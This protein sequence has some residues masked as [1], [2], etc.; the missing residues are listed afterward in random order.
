MNVLFYLVGFLAQL[1]KLLLP[2]LT[3]WVL[4]EISG[5]LLDGLQVFQHR[6]WDFDRVITADM[7]QQLAYV[8]VGIQNALVDVG[9][10]FFAAP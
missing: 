4:D 7:I 6:S 10:R 2:V 1:F 8:V 5:E 9:C 3:N